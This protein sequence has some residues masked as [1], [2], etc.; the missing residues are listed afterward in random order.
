MLPSLVN[1]RPV[2][3]DTDGLAVNVWWVG[4]WD[5]RTPY[6]SWRNG[7]GRIKYVNWG[8]PVF[9]RDGDNEY[10]AFAF[11]IFTEKGT[12]LPIEFKISATEPTTI[13]EYEIQ[14]DSLF[15]DKHV[16]LNAAARK[17]IRD[18]PRVPKFNV[19]F[20]SDGD[21]DLKRGRGDKRVYVPPPRSSPGAA[22]HVELLKDPDNV[23]GLYIRVVETIFEAM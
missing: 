18:P 4:K 17:F 19:E 6:V 23:E 3:L 16:K 2:S 21:E 7:Y 14:L 8:A 10:V 22:A 20:L 11:Q 1:L 9:R 5:S 15:K 12:R 13:K